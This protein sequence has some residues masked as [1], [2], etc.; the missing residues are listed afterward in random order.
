MSRLQ[1][2]EEQI[3]RAERIQRSITDPLSLERLR[4]YAAER[5]REVERLCCDQCCA[6]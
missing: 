2:L 4:Q 3:A 6:A 1:D 5:R